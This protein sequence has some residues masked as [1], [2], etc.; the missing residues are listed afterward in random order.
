MSR[1]KQGISLLLAAAMLLGLSVTALAGE[2]DA[3]CAAESLYL[4]LIHI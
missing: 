4:S 1:L 3:Q 2:P